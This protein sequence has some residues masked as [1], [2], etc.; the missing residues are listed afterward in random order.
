[1]CGDVKTG[2]DGEI[3]AVVF[4]FGG[5]MTTTIMPERVRPVVDELGIPW[6]ALEE[7]FAKY[8]RQMDGGFMTLDEMY[9]KIWADA[10]VE[11]TPEQQARVLKEDTASFLY[12]NECT[13]AWMRELKAKGYR[14]GILTNMPPSFA[15]RFRETFGD[16]IMTA[17]ALVISGEE[18][19]FKPNR[20]I[21]DLEISRLG[22]EPAKTLFIDD[23]VVNCDGA[24]AAGWKVIRFLS[25]AQ[26]E[27]DFAHGLWK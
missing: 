11:I 5:V 25:N 3:D 27:S 6:E 17:D 4:D 24:R 19:M 16:F 13:L 26:A 7:G 18:H 2:F 15:P 22:S 23:S 14:I 9:S 1:M 8:R 21:Y 20:E 10:G 12:R